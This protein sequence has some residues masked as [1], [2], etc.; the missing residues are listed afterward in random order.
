MK[1]FKQHFTEAMENKK[2]V[3]VARGLPGSGKSFTIGKIVPKE[4]IFS[5]DDFWGKDYEFN[6]EHIGDAHAWN[7]RR[8]KD[9]ML[10]GVMPIGIDNTNIKWEH[11]KPYAQMAKES[12]YQVKYLEADSPWWKAISSYLKNPDFKEGNPNFEKVAEF[13]SQKNIHGAPIESIR[14]MLTQWEPTDKLPNENV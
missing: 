9:A 11:I 7:L 1:A 13:L 14:A 5:T 3:Y 4:N 2:I 6:P 12:G 8:A 10:K